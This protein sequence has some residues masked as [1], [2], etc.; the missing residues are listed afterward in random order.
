MPGVP[1]ITFKFLWLDVIAIIAITALLTPVFA[2]G[3]ATG[4]ALTLKAVHRGQS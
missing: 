2:L 4:I 1:V 3:A